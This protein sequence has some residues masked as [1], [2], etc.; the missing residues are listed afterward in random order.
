MARATRTLQALCCPAADQ[1]TKSSSLISI[2]RG[3]V[4]SSLIGS[5]PC[6]GRV[7]RPG[8]GSSRS[9]RLLPRPQFPALLFRCREPLSELLAAAERDADPGVERRG[10][11]GP[12]PPRPLPPPQRA[13]SVYERRA[14]GGA[15]SH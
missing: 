13:P 8:D 7:G 1:A 9:S 2:R 3:A 12:P 14:R 11:G 4:V 10:G 5:P 15:C 6:C